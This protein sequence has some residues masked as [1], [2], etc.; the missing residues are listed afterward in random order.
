VMEEA[1]AEF[2]A[3]VDAG[4][5]EAD[6]VAGI[7]VFIRGGLAVMERYGELMAALLDG[8]APEARTAAM[9]AYRRAG[10]ARRIAQLVQRALDAGALRP[11]LNVDVAAAMLRGAFAPWALGELHGVYDAT[12]VADAFLDLFLRGAGA[13]TS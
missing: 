8:R 11:G 3:A 9:R 7:A 6:V 1:V 2:S 10:T 4:L 13:P 5:A 12:A